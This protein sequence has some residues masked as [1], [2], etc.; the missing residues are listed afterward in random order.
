MTKKTILAGLIAV[1]VLQTAV[2][3]GEYLGAMYPL[4]T[5]Q[6]VRLKTVPFD[7]RSLFRGNYARLRYDI[8]NVPVADL[9]AGE[10]IR[11][12]EVVYVRLRPDDEGMYTY[13]GASLVRPDSGVFLRGRVDQSRRWDWRSTTGSVRVRYGIEA[14]FAPRKKAMAL[15]SKLRRGGVAEI[16]VASNGKATLKSVL[17]LPE[18]PAPGQ[19]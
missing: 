11:G 13:A 2:L 12:G 8:S 7:P 6:P 4:W 10:R 9:G 17:E 15:E 18:S 3:A 5:G 14:F 16:M 1:V 19:P